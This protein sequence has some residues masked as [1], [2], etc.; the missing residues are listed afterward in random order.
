MSL[1]PKPNKTKKSAPKTP[2]S[3][4]GKWKTNKYGQYSLTLGKSEVVID[5]KRKAAKSEKQIYENIAMTLIKNGVTDFHIHVPHIEISR[6][7]PYPLIY[8]TLRGKD[9]KDKKAKLLITKLVK[10]NTAYVPV[11]RWRPDSPWGIDKY[12]YAEVRPFILETWL[13]RW[14]RERGMG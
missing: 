8:M 3:S 9:A 14:K 4:K 10:N 5:K 11:S 13:N 1:K 6:R 2:K 7:S 12:G